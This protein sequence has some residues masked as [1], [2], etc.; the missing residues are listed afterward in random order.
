MGDDVRRA[1][2]RGASRSICRLSS[3]HS[4]QSDCCHQLQ[5]ARGSFLYDGGGEDYG[6]EDY[7]GEDYSG[8][9]GSCS[10]HSPGIWISIPSKVTLSKVITFRVSMQAVRHLHM[11]PSSLP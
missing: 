8:I 11:M 5:F 1:E 7:G 3:D 9:V 6:G 2:R 4:S 10:S